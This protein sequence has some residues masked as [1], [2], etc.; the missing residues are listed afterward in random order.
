VALVQEYV[1]L[2]PQLHLHSPSP[3]IS[4][5]YRYTIHNQERLHGR[6]LWKFVWKKNKKRFDKYNKMGYKGSINQKDERKIKCQKLL[7]Y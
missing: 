4:F 7:I 6:L 2:M 1:W 3:L 5:R